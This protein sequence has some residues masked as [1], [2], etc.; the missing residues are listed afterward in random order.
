LTP[1]TEYYFMTLASNANGVANGKVASFTTSQISG[2]MVVST[3]AKGVMTGHAPN[4]AAAS[5]SAMNSA[6]VMLLAAQFTNGALQI[7]C[8]AVAGNGY[9]LQATTNLSDWI[10]ISTNTSSGSPFYLTE[11][12]STNFSLRFYRAVAEPGK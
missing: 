5:N 6:G 3:D 2:R 1:G 11:A 4:H 10:S 7:E 8:S 9:V 12:N